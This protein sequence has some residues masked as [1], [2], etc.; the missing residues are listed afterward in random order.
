MSLWKSLTVEE[1][2]LLTPEET[3]GDVTVQ[4]VAP[5]AWVK[6]DGRLYLVKAGE[7]LEELDSYGY[8]MMNIL[9]YLIGNTDRHWGNWGALVDNETN[10]P[11]RLHPLMDFNK[12]FLSYDRI[13][14]GNCLTSV[15]P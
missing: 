7:L 14:G 1:T 15:P 2:Q 9:D 11:L 6:R 12:A 4:G 3:A 8:H 10:R 13:E 5:K